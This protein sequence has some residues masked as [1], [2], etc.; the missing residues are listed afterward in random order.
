MPSEP[1]LEGLPAD[2]L[3]RISCMLGLEEL[4]SLRMTCRDFASRVAQGRFVE[5]VEHKRVTFETLALQRFAEM[6]KPGRPGCQM[7]GLCIVG[8]VD[9]FESCCAELL[10]RVFENLK[11]NLASGFMESLEIQMPSEDDDVHVRTTGWRLRW[12]AGN[13]LVREAMRAL[14][15]SGLAVGALDLF[16]GTRCCGLG[17]DSL[18]DVPLECLRG[19]RSVRL[20]LTY[21]S[22]GDGGMDG[23]VRRGCG[24]SSL[25]TSCPNLEAVDLHWYNDDIDHRPISAASDEK[26]F[27]NQ[28]SSPYLNLRNLTLRGISCQSSALLTLL[29]S[30]PKLQ[31]TTLE[32]IHPSG[33]G[34]FKPIPS[35]QSLQHLHLN[36]LTE[37]SNFNRIQ[38]PLQTPLRRPR[39]ASPPHRSAAHQTESSHEEGPAVSDVDDVCCVWREGEGVA[40]VVAVYG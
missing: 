5:Y 21:S 16:A 33:N 9:I 35:F 22:P 24:M 1:T 14:G 34:S 15:G 3:E 40:G 19:L 18:E 27:L 39:Q 7:R 32:H 37:A 6:T 31:T 29:Q 23:D 20:S 11:G 30:A 17:I 36:D 10:G 38:N 4:C 25:L 28:I 2:I 13:V 12:S 8:S 26:H